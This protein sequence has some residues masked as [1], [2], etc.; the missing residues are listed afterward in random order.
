MEFDGR[1]ITFPIVLDDKWNREALERYT[2]TIRDK[3]VYLPSNVEYL[4]RNNGL[5][6]A[7]EALEK[8][9]ESDWVCYICERQFLFSSNQPRTDGSR[10]FWG[11]DFTLPALSLYR[12]TTSASVNRFAYTNDHEARPSLSP[13]WSENESF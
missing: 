7:K 13:D 1:R 10:L 4:A 9:I 8:L 3:A 6:N 2:S 5:S 11:L 12:Y